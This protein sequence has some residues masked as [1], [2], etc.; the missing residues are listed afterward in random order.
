MTTL[1]FPLSPDQTA[2][3][4]A[5]ESWLTL[6]YSPENAFFVLRGYAGTGKTTLMRVLKDQIKGRM[7]FTAPTNKAT[8]VL[9]DMMTEPGYRPECRTIY[10]LLGLQLSPNGEVKELREPEDPVELGQFRAIIVDE[11]SMVNAQIIQHIRRAS[12]EQ[13]VRFLFLGDPAQLP[14]V[15]ELHSPIWQSAFT[16]HGAAM[17]RVM[18]HDNTILTLATE[19]RG[20]VNHPAPS[21]RGFQD[22]HDGTEGV[23]RLP[24]KSGIRSIIEDTEAGRFQSAGA[25]KIIA[26]R[27]ATVDRYNALVRSYIFE[28]LDPAIPWAEDD[29]V[30]FTE[31]AK[32]LNDK[33]IASTDDEG[34]VTRVVQSLHPVW[35]EFRIHNVSVAVDG[36][37][38]IIARVLHPQ[39]Q[40]KYSFQVERL[41]S[42]ARAMPRKWPAF[43]EFKES[44]HSLRHAYAITTHRAQGSTYHTAFVDATD[45]LANPQ[46]QEAFRCLYT[47]F[48][49]PSKRLVIV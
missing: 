40:Q 49:R 23:W 10:S 39:D 48:T 29:R 5:I 2:A 4:A 15:K 30:I 7:I 34:R 44:F 8:K 38:L 42:E 16:G 9:R 17:E 36:G 26:W 20:K 13:Q 25:S 47:A 14:P 37:D 32:D 3:L 6:P 1:P 31:P 19:V 11:G 28:E 33:P 18:R 46:R 24:G 45:I 27:N 12:M 22:A 43:W 21:L 35:P 41:A